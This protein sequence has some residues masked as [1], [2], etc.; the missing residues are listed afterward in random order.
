MA[1]RPFAKRIV[2][3]ISRMM[4][5]MAGFRHVTSKYYIRIVIL[6]LSGLFRCLDAI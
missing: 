2:I 4:Q 5:I 1:Y 6:A 3:E